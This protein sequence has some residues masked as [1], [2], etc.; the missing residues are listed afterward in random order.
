ML[1]I[2]E[3]TPNFTIEFND[4]L[5]TLNFKPSPEKILAYIYAVLHSTTYRKKYVE[6]LKIDFPAVPFAN[7]KATFERYA[8]LGQKL[9]DLHLLKNIPDDKEIKV[10]GNLKNSFTI[11]SI[12]HINNNL[13][14]HTMENKR[15][16]F[17]GITKDIY[18]F[19][20][21]SYKPIDKWLKYRIKDEVSLGF[22]DIK[23]LKEV[24]IVIKETQKVMEEIDGLWDFSN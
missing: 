5:R 13:F 24:T 6:F 17:D 7:D 18:N 19:E 20:I 23:H 8:K 9:I 11:K 10:S 21:G 1:K 15:I 2:S 4:F 12:E 16:S 22:Q 3:K 14:L